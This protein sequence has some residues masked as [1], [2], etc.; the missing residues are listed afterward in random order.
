MRACGIVTLTTDFGL[1]DAYAAQLHAALLRVNPALRIVDV[2]HAVPPGDA[3]AALF[4]SECAWPA[5]PDGAV[6]VLVVDPGV[7]S[8]RGLV[9]I[10]TDRAWLVGP[11]TGVLSSGLPASMRP[12]AGTAR[13]PLPDG[14]R[15]ADIRETPLAAPEVSRTFHGRDLMAPVAAAL[16]SGRDVA[17]VGRPLS[18]VTAAAPLATPLIGGAGEGRILHVDRFGNAITSF[19]APD[20]GAAFEVEAGGRTVAGPAASYAAGGSEV[21]ALPSSSGYVELA[22]A[23]GSAA[24]ALGVGRGA[25]VRLRRLHGDG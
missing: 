2:S 3:T 19:R 24:A 13:S 18:E 11:D 4:L 17:S 7:G 21:V 25:P 23:N 14:L 12:A 8:A 6:H 9:A 16:A 22:L 15:A 10:E 1:G 5:F 20:A